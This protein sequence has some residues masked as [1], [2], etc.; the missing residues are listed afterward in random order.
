MQKTIKNLAKA[1][2]GESQAR[3]RYT[4]YAKAAKKEGYNQLEEIFL[5]TAEN[6]KEHA[7]WLMRMINELKEKNE[8]T[9]QD[10]KEIEVE[11]GM[12]TIFG[13]TEENL[14]SAIEGENY[15]K[16]Q[17]YPDFAQIAEEEGLPEIAKRLRH[18][19]KAE[20]HHEERFQK[21]LEQ[22]QKGTMFKKE[23]SEEWMCRECGYV[24]QGEEPPRECPSCSHPYN[25]FQVKCE[26]Y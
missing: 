15:E 8:D 2:I 6:E 4:F 12:P 18:I 20:D 5:L 25:Y 22:I 1:F 23:E 7:K 21:F 13:T 26:K 3:N 19:G 9:S 17:M 11:A 14:K 10:L 16:T 24:H